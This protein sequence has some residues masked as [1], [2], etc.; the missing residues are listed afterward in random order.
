VLD[1]VNKKDPDRILDLVHTGEITRL[2]KSWAMLQ[3]AKLLAKTDRE[4][5]LAVTD[6][7]TLEARRIETSDADRPRA[8]MNAA[9]VLLLTDRPK[10]WDAVYEAIKAANS[11]EGFTGE[12]GVI[13]ISLRTKSIGSIRSSTVA[14][15]NVAGIF[16]ELAKE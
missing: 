3:A 9:N 13:R 10:A 11:A 5:S 15:F 14:E 2:Q 6:E 7:A 4:K 1:A 12:D 8:L 16:S